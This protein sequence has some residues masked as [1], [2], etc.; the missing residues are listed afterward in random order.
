[1]PDVTWPNDRRQA[2]ADRAQGCCEYC[3][4]RVDYSPSAFS[5]EHIIPKIAGGTEDDVNLAFS[6]QSC[7]NHKYIKTSAHDPLTG[8]IAPLYNPRRQPWQKHFMWSVDKALIIGITPTGRATVERL[9]VNRAS[10]VN[11]RRLLRSFGE[12][13]PPHTVTLGTAPL[14]HGN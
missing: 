8:E 12:H 9:Q 4:S 5:I 7:N 6:C 13:P 3:L 1:M 11:L 14:E 2:I 10:V